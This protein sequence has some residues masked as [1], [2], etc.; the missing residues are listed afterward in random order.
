METNNAQHKDIK[1]PQKNMHK[2]QKQEI[3]KNEDWS[4]KQDAII[5]RNE[6]IANKI[7]T[8]KEERINEQDEH[9]I[10]K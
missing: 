1:N 10:H 3:R 7:R 2:N 5:T 8:N 6:E 4:K 9:I